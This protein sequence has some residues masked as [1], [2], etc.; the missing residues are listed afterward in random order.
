M[1]RYGR[2]NT[3]ED[4][5]RCIAEV[6]EPPHYIYAHQCRRKRGHGPDGE[7]CVQHAKK[8]AEGRHVYVGHPTRI[9]GR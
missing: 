6:S 8:L 3:P 2:S 9:V 5:E 7:Y 4:R 1:R